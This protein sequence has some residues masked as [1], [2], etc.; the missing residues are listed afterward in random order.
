M[1]TLKSQFLHKI[2]FETAHFIASYAVI[3]H[4]LEFINTNNAIDKTTQLICKTFQHPL[5]I[6]TC[7]AF[8]VICLISN[9]QTLMKRKESNE[10]SSFFAFVWEIPVYFFLM[11]ELIKLSC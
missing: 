9:R 10:I 11:D 4:S 5:T 8:F 6:L 3:F 2:L 1:C 7:A